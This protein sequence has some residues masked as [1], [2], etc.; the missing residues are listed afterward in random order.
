[1]PRAVAL[2]SGGL[3][4]TLAIRIM[5]ERGFDVDALNIRTTFD[6]CRAAA[7]RAAADLGVRLTV[8]PVADD[9]ID[10]IRKPSYGYGK[11]V[12]PCVDCRIYM[13]KMAR[14]LMEEVG[15]C[16]VVTGEILGQRPMS[17][18]R[19]DLQIV[20]EQSGL[21]G[22]LL[23]P[24][25]AK[26]LPPTVPEQE[27]VVDREKLY[28]FH[29][30]RRSELVELAR[31]LGIREIPQPSVGCALTEVTF[32]PRVRDLMQFQP[33]ASRWD[34]E[35]LNV[36]RH[37]RLDA[38]TKLVIGRNADD[39][40]LLRAFFARGDATASAIMHPESF[41]GPDVLI[42]GRV[43]EQAIAFAGGLMFR[44][45]RS[46]DPLDAEVSLTVRDFR[47]LIRIAPDPAAT[48][49]ALL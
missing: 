22:R 1:M 18:K 49:A 25:S 33:E 37:L 8:L 11:G 15:A 30:R 44:Y 7:A 40:A 10:V 46:I 47:R 23:R 21:G 2:F 48:E 34:F 35:L 31:R 38:R 39:N 42:V 14:R 43:A 4:S 36:G 20:A 45:S 9:Y 3:D 27:G 29:G 28:G 5:Q 19:R 32:A 26:Q 17:Q 16:M 24:L 13:C 6:C 12:N 41:L